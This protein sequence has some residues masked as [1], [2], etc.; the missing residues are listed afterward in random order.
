MLGRQRVRKVV[1]P[2]S[3]ILGGAFLVAFLPA[4]SASAVA[5]QAAVVADGRA[6]YEENC[7][8]CHGPEG[9]GDGPMADILV[10][11][12]SDLTEIAQQNDGNFPFWRIYEA[13]DGREPVEGHATFQ[14]PLLESRFA[15][16]QGKPGYLPPHIRILLLVH[17]VESLQVR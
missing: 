8:A 6:E 2:C 4:V 13:I 3:S 7:L 5:Q 17:Y 12:P 1:S 14:M 11:A 10:I 9:R 16:D 15:R